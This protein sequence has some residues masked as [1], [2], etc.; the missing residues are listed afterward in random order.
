M[1]IGWRMQ[2]RWSRAYRLAE[3]DVA[4]LHPG[5]FNNPLVQSYWN[6]Q[7][8]SYSSWQRFTL[9]T[10]RTKINTNLPPATTTKVH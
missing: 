4:E 5:I 6:T 9:Y 1:R 2:F 3:K 8:L 7:M 10:T